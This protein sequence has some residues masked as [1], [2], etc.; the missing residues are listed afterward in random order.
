MTAP[1]TSLS[2]HAWYRFTGELARIGEKIV[3][4][5]GARSPR[6]RAEGY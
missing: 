3:G 5:T 1:E 6:E 2:Q 4:P